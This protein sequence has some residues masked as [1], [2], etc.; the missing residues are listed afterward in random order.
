MFATM[1]EAR[2]VYINHFTE[3][4]KWLDEF[5]RIAKENGK[6]FNPMEHLSRSDWEKYNNWGIKLVGMEQ[7]LG[8]TPTEVQEVETKLGWKAKR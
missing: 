4:I 5:K 2:Q 8:M 3:Y 7:A 1:Q 6:K